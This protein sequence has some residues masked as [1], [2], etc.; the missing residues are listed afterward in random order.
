MG[1]SEKEYYRLSEKERQENGIINSFASWAVAISSGVALGI[2]LP[3][4][5]EMLTA[6][7]AGHSSADTRHAIFPLLVITIS[8]VVLFL[9][10]VI[11]KW[12]G[13]WFTGMLCFHITYI[14]YL[15]EFGQ[16]GSEAHWV[17]SIAHPIIIGLLTVCLVLSWAQDRYLSNNSK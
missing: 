13:K 16:H 10:A 4:A 5:G 6:S 12:G 1:I 14:A 11:E 8:S 7:L 17:M 15:Y 9:L 3:V 2:M